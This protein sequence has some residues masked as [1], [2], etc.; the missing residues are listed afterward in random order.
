MS[1]ATSAWVLRKIGEVGVDTAMILIAD[2][3]H[4][5][6]IVDESGNL[7]T[8]PLSRSLGVEINVVSDGVYDV[9]GLFDEDGDIT[10]IRIPLK[11]EVL[12]AIR[13]AFKDR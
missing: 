4:L 3:C 6:S 12:A 9:F 2:P 8:D 11:T 13:E 1:S 10:E 7:R 5:N